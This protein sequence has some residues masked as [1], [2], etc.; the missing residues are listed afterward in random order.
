MIGDL[1]MLVKRLLCK[2]E[3]LDLIPPRLGHA[4]GVLVI[5]VPGRWRQVDPCILLASHSSLIYEFQAT[6]IHNI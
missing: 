3:D 5:P 2:Q 4:L 6:K 1:S